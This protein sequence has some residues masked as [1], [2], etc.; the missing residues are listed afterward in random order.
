[1]N[2]EN[3][4]DVIFEDDEFG[5]IDLGQQ[6][7]EG[8][9]GDQPAGQQ[10]PSA[11]PDEDLT[12]EVL[13]LKGITDPGKIKFEDETGAIVERAWDS[14]S[15]EEQINILI[16]QEVEQQD[17]DDSEL[18]LIN[19]IRESGMTP[20]EYIQS[21]LP[22]TE[23]TKRYK[24]DDLSDDEVYALDLLHKVGSDI[25]D[26][27][28]NQALE[29]A[30]QNE[31]LFKKTVEGLRKEYIRL[32]EDEEAQIANEK[33]AREEAAYNRFADSIKG[34][35]KGQIKE[36]DSFA[37]QPLQ[38]S[39]D[40]IEDLSSFMLEIDDQ[41]LSA[42]GRAMNDPALFTKAA[43]WILNEDKIVEELNKQIQDNYRRGYEQ[44]KA[45]LQGKPKPKLV[46]NKPASQKKTTDDVF[47]DDEDWY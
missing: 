47:I 31:G 7:P 24:V 29:L 45:D 35:I 16:D 25:S 46:F 9:E 26:E 13:R 39:D 33:A 43:F 14:L 19:T 23:P 4:D 28:I 8:N 10:K 21:L 5:D 38:L 44:A 3:F 17:F 1:M 12:T 34:Q 27:E 20:D 42:F 15:R 36:L 30:K 40:D 11:Q 41:G 18:Q 32:Q 2:M 37:G 6:K 22:E